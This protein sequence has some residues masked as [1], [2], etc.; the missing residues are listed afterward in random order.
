[1]KS[2]QKQATYK[3]QSKRMLHSGM[4]KRSFS[5]QRNQKTYASQNQDN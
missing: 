5:K 4:I 1:M 2:Y 3:L